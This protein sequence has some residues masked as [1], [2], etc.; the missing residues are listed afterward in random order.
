M[1]RARRGLIVEVT[2]NDLLGAGGNPLSQ[3]VKLALK[4]MALNMA[5]ELKSRGVAAVAITP[6]FLRSEKMLEN[7]G[8]S[9]EHWRDGGKKDK[10]F[11]ESE[12]PLFVGRA[13]AA[14]AADPKRPGA[15]RPSVEFLGA[16]ATLWLYRRGRPPAG[17]G[18]PLAGFSGLPPWLVELLDT[19]FH[20][21]LEW[22]TALAGRTE[23]YIANW[24]MPARRRVK[25]TA[26]SR[27]R[28][29]R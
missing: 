23:R 15:V 9:E 7:F 2:E 4:V 19:G 17:L 1:I 22:L 14:L 11:L 21:Q 26:A 28:A 29:R 5:T 25:R 24:R 8:V 6:G 12:T 18:R 10:N 27:G 16:G 20:L 3:I 13:V